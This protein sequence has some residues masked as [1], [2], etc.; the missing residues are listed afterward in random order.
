MVYRPVSPRWVRSTEPI[1]PLTP[2]ISIFMVVYV[3]S[4]WLAAALLRPV[5]IMLSRAS[6]TGGSNCACMEPRFE[7]RF[8]Q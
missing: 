6:S 8:E 4:Y 5:V 1:N 7:P 2:V 3:P